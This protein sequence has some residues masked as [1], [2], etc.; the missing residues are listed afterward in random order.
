MRRFYFIGRRASGPLKVPQ[1]QHLAQRDAFPLRPRSQ[2]RATALSRSPVCA[3]TTAQRG[4]KKSGVAQC[5]GNLDWNFHAQKI[6]FSICTRALSFGGVCSISYITACVCL[7][8]SR[9]LPGARIWRALLSPYSPT[10]RRAHYHKP[11]SGEWVRMKTP[12]RAAETVLA[13]NTPWASRTHTGNHK[14]DTSGLYLPDQSVLDGII[15]KI[16]KGSPISL[17]IFFE[18]QW[19]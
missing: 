11:D 12:L 13:P 7:F 8:W 1:Q 16:L 3:F 4:S 19:I 14:L 9:V 15:F 2:R 17:N 10:P 6:L 5:P 18:K